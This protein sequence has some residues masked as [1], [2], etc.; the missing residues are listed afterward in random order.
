MTISVLPVP[1][2]DPRFAEA[3]ALVAPPGAPDPEA[4][5]PCSPVERSW[6]VRR[7]DQLRGRAVAQP[8]RGHQ[9]AG[10]VALFECLDDPEAAAALLSACESFLRE[11]GCR[12][13][14]GP[15]DGD[16]WHGYRTAQASEF[17]P[18]RLDRTT[19]AWYGR[20]FQAAG[21]EVG[22]EY[23]S[24]WIDRA[25]LSWNRLDRGLARLA[26]SGGRIEVFDPEA[27]DDQLD[28]LHGLSQAAFAHNAWASP[29]DRDDFHA[30]YRGFRAMIAPDW[31]QWAVSGDGTPL[32]Y[33]FSIPDRRPDGASIRV[34]KTVAVSDRPEARGLGALLV[35][36][37]H[38]RA[39]DE[40]CSGVVHALMHVRNPS[41]LILSRHAEVVRR[42]HL[43][44]KDLP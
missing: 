14:L 35:E 42:Y 24:T 1:R 31:I 41:T 27:W 40:G 28:R 12:R 7:D 26:A 38:R 34:V 16:T 39:F 2:S 9:G 43:W 6:I 37:V 10:N 30:L 32:G 33:V 21:Y 3:R 29:L 44:I 25:A 22:E 11:R 13:V 20:L 19:P 5:C 17:A 15:L 4:T 18:F 23:V 8:L 36:L